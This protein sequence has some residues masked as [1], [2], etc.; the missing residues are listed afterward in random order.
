ML[1]ALSYDRIN[2]AN[3]LPIFSRHIELRY[4]PREGRTVLGEGP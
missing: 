4:H 3:Y 2:R 1:Q